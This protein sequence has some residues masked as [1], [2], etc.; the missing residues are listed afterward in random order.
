MGLRTESNI[1]H[2]MRRMT[3]PVLGLAATTTHVPKLIALLPGICS[4]D[5][6]NREALLVQKPGVQCHLV[7]AFPTFLSHQVERI[8]FKFCLHPRITLLLLVDEL[9]G[10]ASI[11]LLFVKL[12]MALTP[13][14]PKTRLPWKGLAPKPE[15]HAVVALSLTDECSLELVIACAN[16]TFGVQ[17]KQIRYSSRG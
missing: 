7:V 4:I 12:F 6:L 11:A 5:P 17:F 10:R 9:V 14:P 1:V 2:L 3:Q 15:T 8:A 16:M 13:V